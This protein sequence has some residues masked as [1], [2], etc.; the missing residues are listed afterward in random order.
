[1]VHDWQHTNAAQGGYAS[2]CTAQW[3]GAAHAI[4]PAGTSRSGQHAGA[5]HG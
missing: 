2:L 5:S 1:M 3:A 4:K